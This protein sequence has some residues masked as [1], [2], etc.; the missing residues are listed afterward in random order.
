MRRLLAAAAALTALTCAGGSTAYA[1]PVPAGHHVGHVFVIVLEN[2]NFQDAYVDN[3][4]HY[5]GRD[6]Q[7]KGTLLTRYYGTGHLSND[8]YIAM[9]SGQAPNPAN[10]SDCQ[11][12]VDFQPSPAVFGPNGQA[13]GT[14]CVYPANVL[15]LADQL[16]AKHLRWRGYMEDMGKDPDR[17]PDRCGAPASSFGTG[18][19]DGTQSA[20]AKDQYAARH[21][22]FVYFHSVIDDNSCTRNVLP[23]PHLADDL[24]QLSTTPAFSFITPDLC[25][26]GHDTPCADGRPGGLKSV[27]AFLRAWVPRIMSSPAFAKDGLLVITSDESES[28]TSESC[29]GEQPGP[30]SPDP[31]IY[32][33][34][35]GMGGGR[36]GALVIGSCVRAG[37]KDA[38][39]YNH[40][41][42]LRSLEDVFGI[43]SGGADGKGHLGFAGATGLKS[44]GRDVFGGCT[45]APSTGRRTASGDRVA[46]SGGGSL[47]ATGGSSAAPPL[48][49]LLVLLAIG[50]VRVVLTRK[51]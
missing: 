39:P 1:G 18:M 47:A 9:L 46:F 25:S 31:G 6:L 49:L 36:V 19:Q 44:F 38:T 10:Q 34:G 35:G 41:S 50:L 51:V 45:S 16:D 5:L 24:K 20:T 3:P 21:N 32:P 8:N 43:S 4:N 37:V 22:P 42:L 7:R 29:C 28:K 12:Y 27:D 17:E 48:A 11:D 26:D 15:T 14:G 23:L 30:N 40:Y 2:R 33:S 13:I